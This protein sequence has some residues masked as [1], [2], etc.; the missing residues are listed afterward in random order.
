MNAKQE[1]LQ[2][3]AE[4]GNIKCA[5]VHH[6]DKIIDM[7]IG[8]P[9]RRFLNQLDFEYDNGFGYQNL[10][11]T[12]WFVDGTW[13]TRGEYDGAEWWEHHK[14]PEIPAELK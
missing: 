6:D 8:C 4:C 2:L 5:T 1:M 12:A 7:P 9:V 3:I 13:A 14:L 11:G 10:D